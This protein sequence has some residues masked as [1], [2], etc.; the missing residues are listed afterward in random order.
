MARSDDSSLRT[1]R[2]LAALSTRIADEASAAIRTAQDALDEQVRRAALTNDPLRHYLA[3]MSLGL[4]AMHKL[5]VDG[6]LTLGQQIEAATKPPLS[7]VDVDTIGWRVVSSVAPTVEDAFRKLVRTNRWLV[8]GVLVVAVVLRVAARN[9][10]R[11]DAQ[12]RAVSDAH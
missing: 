7:A 1:D 2:Q 4:D 10:N 11:P 5:F 12:S 6:A 9:H 8:A 3:A